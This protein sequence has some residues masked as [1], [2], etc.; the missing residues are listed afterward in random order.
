MPDVH[1]LVI[2]P[3]LP[4]DPKPPPGTQMPVIEPV[5]SPPTTTPDAPVS[6]A[7]VQRAA[8]ESIADAAD[9]GT[10]P[11]RI[12]VIEPRLPTQPTPPPGTVI[13]R[14]PTPT[15]A[16]A[17]TPASSTERPATPATDGTEP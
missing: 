15:P 5:T 4:D 6:A 14:P 7:A 11:V 17:P 9:L 1:I 13:T 2:E 16:I 8:V 3:P 12:R 10:P